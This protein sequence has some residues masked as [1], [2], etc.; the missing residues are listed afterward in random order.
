MTFDYN[1][2]S[3]NRLEFFAGAIIPNSISTVTI[4]VCMNPFYIIIIGG[5]LIIITVLPEVIIR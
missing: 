2:E 1:V 4:I 3:E 5:E